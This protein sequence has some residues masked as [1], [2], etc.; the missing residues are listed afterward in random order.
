MGEL[1]IL[2]CVY[3]PLSAKGDPIKKESNP[4][5]RYLNE[6]VTLKEI[7]AANN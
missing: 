6:N 1:R 5:A 2:S 3:K 4:N 7:I